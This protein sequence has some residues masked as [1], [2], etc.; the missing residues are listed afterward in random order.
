MRRIILS[1]LVIY[2]LP[3]FVH[4]SSQNPIVEVKAPTVIAFF[5]PVTKD[6]L[7]KDDELNESLSD[8]Q[9]HLHE[10]TPTLE[11]A[12]IKVHELYTK[13]FTLKLATS[14]ITFRP[15]DTDVGYYFIMPGKKPKVQYGVMTDVDL[16]SIASDYFGKKLL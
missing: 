4:A 16:L 9:H 8:F 7:D 12:G 3:V 11:K 10:A 6:E 5:G 14:T 15:K 2:L 13:S 1:M